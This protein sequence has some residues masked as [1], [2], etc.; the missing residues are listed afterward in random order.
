M[1]SG[2]TG[3]PSPGGRVTKCWYVLILLSQLCPTLKGGVSFRDRGMWRKQSLAKTSLSIF[4]TPATEGLCQG[5]FARIRKDEFGFESLCTRRTCYM[6]HIKT[7][8][9]ALT[10]LIYRLPWKGNG[11]T[12]THQKLG[13]RLPEGKCNR[14]FSKA[15][16]QYSPS[17]KIPKH[18]TPANAVHHFCP[19]RNLETAVYTQITSLN[20]R[21]KNLPTRQAK[22]VCFMQPDLDLA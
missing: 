16:P 1:S 18:W 12:H 2:L 11:L 7:A 14:H 22:G 3:F 13:D 9:Y 21:P 20:F 8:V 4:L 10:D 17:V 5:C 15:I 19:M 6:L